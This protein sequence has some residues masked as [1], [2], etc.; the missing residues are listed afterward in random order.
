MNKLVKR[1]VKE[2][3]NTV[4]ILVGGWCARHGSNPL[5]DPNI[6]M[7]EKGAVDVSVEN[8]VHLNRAVK[9]LTSTDDHNAALMA[10]NLA[11]VPAMHLYRVVDVND[12]SDCHYKTLELRVLKVT[13]K[14]YCIA[15]DGKPKW[16]SNGK[17]G[18]RNRFAFEN[19]SSAMVNYIHRKRKHIQI[20][21][22]KL[23]RTKVALA[24]ASHEL[25]D[26]KCPEHNTDPLSSL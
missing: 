16:V 17:G 18:C 5:T 22:H 11:P 9:N 25:N 4:N 26:T 12:G 14:G 6:R 20:L 21:Q 15:H 7:K 3:T 24:L 1:L 19:E 10:G 8:I 13:E 23:E 2:A